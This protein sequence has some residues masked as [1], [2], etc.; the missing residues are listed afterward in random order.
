[1]VGMCRASALAATAE[2]TS[3]FGGAFTSA[4]TPVLIISS[5][6]A[7]NLVASPWAFSMSGSKPS[8]SIACPSSGS[9]TWSHCAEVSMSGRMMPT[10]I[11]SWCRSVT[12]LVPPEHPVTVRMSPSVAASTVRPI[13]LPIVGSWFV[14]VGVTSRRCRAG[15]GIL[16]AP[17]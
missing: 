12:L 9:S 4:L 17:A 13:V 3:L 16:P 2:P 1:M 5:A 14:N 11:S 7:A 8:V 10:L 6:I 15:C